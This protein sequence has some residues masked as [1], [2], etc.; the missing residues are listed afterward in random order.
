MM[1]NIMFLLYKHFMKHFYINRSTQILFTD[2]CIVHLY[3]WK[4]FSKLVNTLQ[5]FFTDD[6][7]M[8][9]L[10]L[11]YHEGFYFLTLHSFYKR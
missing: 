6:I 9:E 3:C 7:V 5:V 10:F 1:M 8:M 2:I 4:R 11:V